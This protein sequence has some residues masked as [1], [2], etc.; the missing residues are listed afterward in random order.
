VLCAALDTHLTTPSEEEELDGG[1]RLVVVGDVLLDRDIIGTVD[2]RS[3]EAPVPI[4]SGT[5][6]VDRPGGAGLA[7]VLAA[8]EPG[9]RITLVGGIG[10]DAPGARVRELLYQAGVE[11]TSTSP[12]LA[13]PRS[14]PASAPATAPCSA[15]TRRTPRC[16]SARSRTKPVPGWPRPQPWWY[17]TTG[18]ASPPITN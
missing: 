1:R 3:P 6:A 17:A 5:H 13:P 4:V 7:A 2:R 8:R 11:V 12:P 14:R 18:A 9:W 16:A 10:Q 15:T